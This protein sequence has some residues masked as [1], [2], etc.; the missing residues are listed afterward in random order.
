MEIE[1]ISNDN[2]PDIKG[3]FD[4]VLPRHNELI[5]IE[6]AVQGSK[7]WLEARKTGIGGSEVAS[8]LGLSKWMSPLELWRKK[9]GLDPDT[10]A[11]WI[12]KQGSHNESLIAEEWAEQNSIKLIQIPF[13][14]DINHPHRTASLDYIGVWPD[15]HAEVLEIK[16][17]PKG[18]D[19]VPSYYYT[20]VMWY[21]AITGIHKGRL[22]VADPWNEPEDRPIDWHEETANQILD[23]VD[24]WW[25]TCMVGD[26]APEPSSVDETKQVAFG[27][28][29]NSNGVI[30]A[31][32]GTLTDIVK[33]L[34][35]AKALRDTAEDNVKA[36]D[37]ELAVYMAQLGATKV[38]G[39]DWTISFVERV[40]S[41]KYGEVVKALNVPKETLELYR[42]SPSRFITVRVK[43]EK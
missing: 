19:G 29:S 35:E 27:K 23:A 13:V 11:T 5:L 42:G 40:G 17:S 34:V 33:R 15:G 1:P 38:D 4:Y 43:G 7:E 41:V 25:L 14:R 31:P 39:G 2:T 26:E 18:V 20:Q 32:D 10:K 8:V 6:S 9:K 16:Y 37:A 12:M 3:E 21:M 36:L 22:I 28:L 24:N 30:T